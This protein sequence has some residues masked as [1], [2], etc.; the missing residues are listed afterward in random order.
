[1]VAIQLTKSIFI[2]KVFSWNQQ[3]RTKSKMHVK[4]RYSY[5]YNSIKQ[6]Y[7]CRKPPYVIPFKI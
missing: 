5:L 2:T 4:A 3:V 7:H 6:N 1:M